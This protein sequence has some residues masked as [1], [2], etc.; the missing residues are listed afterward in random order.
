VMNQFSCISIL[1]EQ[2]W[3]EEEAKVCVFR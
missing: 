1:R 2:L 3:L